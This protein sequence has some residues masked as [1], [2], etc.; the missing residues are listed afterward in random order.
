LYRVGVVEFGCLGRSWKIIEYEVKEREESV[1]L[2]SE[3]V[4][5]EE[6]TP[7][8][9]FSLLDVVAIEVESGEE[10]VEAWSGTSGNVVNFERLVRRLKSGTRC[11]LGDVIYWD[12]VDGILDVGNMSE[13]DTAFDETPEEVVGIRRRRG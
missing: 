7:G 5:L 6:G 11:D 13:L 2:G 10:P 3:D 12:H 8:K 1:V 4:L 9:V